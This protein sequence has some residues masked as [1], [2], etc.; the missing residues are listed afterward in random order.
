MHNALPSPITILTGYYGSG[1]TEVA[2]NLAISAASAGE[3]VHLIDLDGLKPGFRSRELAATLT[4]SGVKLVAPT[5]ILANADMPLVPPTVVPLLT[6]KRRGRIV[7]DLGGDPGGARALA[8][9][10]TLLKQ[11]DHDLVMVVNTMRPF[12]STLERIL[13]AL[14]ELEESTRM[15]ITGLLANTHLGADTDA[16][17][18]ERGCALTAEAGR[19]VGLPVLAVVTPVPVD[20]PVPQVRIQ[21]Y[22]LP[23]WDTERSSL[24]CQKAP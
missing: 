19:H 18:I 7:I 24:L 20:V 2:V 9:F 21:R 16:A 13:T 15:R 5:G 22:V 12:S 6:G 4:Q 10:S 3:T 1:K 8:Q 23:P 17:M 14:A 11:I